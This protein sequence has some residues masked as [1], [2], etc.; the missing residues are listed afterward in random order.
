MLDLRL[1]QQPGVWITATGTVPLAL[2]TSAGTEQPVDLEIKSSD[3]DLGL[4]GGL[5]DVIRD[6]HGKLTVNVRAS[7]TNRDP[8][9]I[10]DVTLA[11]AA[12]TVA[13]TGSAYKNG[14]AKVN[15][16]TDRIDVESFH[17]EDA[18]GRALEVRGGLGTHE[19]RVGDLAIEATARRFEIM[20]N[21]FG[22]I[23]ID[24]ALKLGGQWEAPLVTGDLTIASGDVRVD[25]ILQRTLFQPYATEQTAI[26]EGDAVAALNP[27]DRLGVDVAL[28]VP[29]NTLRL[30]GEN[31]Q[32]TTGTP[33]GLGDINLR[34]R[35]DLSLFKIPRDPDQ[36]LYVN[37]SFD[38]VTGTFSFMGRRFDLQP[39]QLD[40]LPR[41][42]DPGCRRLRDARDFRRR[43]P[44]RHLRAAGAAVA[45]HVQ[46]PAARRIRHPV[47][48]RVQQLDQPVV[49]RAATG[50][51]RP[52]R[53]AGGGSD[54]D[55]AACPRS[56]TR[57]AW[58]FS[59]SIR[60]ANSAAARG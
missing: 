34:V 25:E 20:R 53:R 13:A 52:R 38:Q 44:R 17:L 33:L 12:F 18:N 45:A 11:D 49:G 31:I 47:A 39:E 36:R 10:G 56:K 48:D 2:F 51:D 55:A 16:T 8:H 22:R 27:W 7:N 59:R 37:G 26:I 57:S 29:N 24:A 15:L 23:E 9:F 43:D 40:Q 28:H 58:I 14:R 42:S 41:R 3:I 50:A 4:L 32:V 1:D 5:T 30:A 19:M 35:G 54:R 21:E 46:R 60:R 6:M